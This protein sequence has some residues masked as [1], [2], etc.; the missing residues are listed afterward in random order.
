MNLTIVQIILEV[1]YKL[2]QIELH[3]MVKTKTNRFLVEKSEFFSFFGNIQP[4]RA[5]GRLTQHTIQGN[6]A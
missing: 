1:G 2:M 3:S 5:A 6:P 4:S